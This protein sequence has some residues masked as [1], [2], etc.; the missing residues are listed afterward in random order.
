M[1]EHQV[2]GLL[3][4][5]TPPAHH[6]YSRVRGRSEIYD[7]AKTSRRAAAPRFYLG[8]L[9]G[10]DL[11]EVV[12]LL[13]APMPERAIRALGRWADAPDSVGGLV[14]ERVAQPVVLGKFRTDAAAIVVIHTA[15]FLAY[16][17]HSWMLL[18]AIGGR[19]LII[20]LSD[21]AIRRCRSGSRRA[22]TGLTAQ[23]RVHR[24]RDRGGLSGSRC[25]PGRP[26]RWAV[27]VI[28]RP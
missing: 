19:A 8:L 7:P 5:V 20:S 22:A 4:A 6:R 18:A 26:V 13:L 21:N 1:G 23:Q 28:F 15:A 9:G 24:H 10:L 16:G 3:R 25:R 14:L 11:L 17:A 27:L 12:A 2:R